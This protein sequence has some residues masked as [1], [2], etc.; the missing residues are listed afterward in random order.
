MSSK[1]EE[2]VNLILSDT[3]LTGGSAV[4]RDEPIIKT[5]SQMSN[6]LPPFLREMRRLASGVDPYQYT[7]TRIFIKQARFAAD[8]EDDYTT[9]VDFFR[10][11]PTY[12]SMND[13]QLRCYFAWRTKVRKGIV[14]HAATS[15]AFVYV[16]EL[17][18]LVGVKSAQ[19]GYDRLCSL[20]K[21]FGEYD[22]SVSYYINLWLTDFV[23]YYGLDP[24]LI[25]EHRADFDSNLL[26]LVHYIEHSDGE[27]FSAILA[28]SS[29]NI[30][31]SKF[32][33]DNKDDFRRVAISVYR[34][35]AQHFDKNRKTSLCENY[36][37][38]VQDYPHR[39]FSSA[40]FLDERKYEHYEYKINEF[41]SY[42]CDR[43]YWRKRVFSGKREKN[44]QLGAMMKAVDCIMRNKFGDPHELQLPKVTKMI[45]KTIEASTDELLEEKQKKAQPKIEIDL[46]VLQSIRSDSA[47]TRDRLIVDEEDFLPEEVAENEP[48]FAEKSDEK[49]DEKPSEILQKNISEN[50]EKFGLN[51]AEFSVLN[52]L[53]YGGDYSQCARSN[54]LLLSVVIDSI[55][56][57]LFDLLGDTAIAFDSDEPHIL[58]DYIDELKGIFAP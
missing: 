43:G 49:I 24:S 15:Y 14:E 12:S 47:Q 37:G 18:N 34:K 55:N 7:D 44:R 4:Y 32:Y 39:M 56:E 9:K 48:I 21:S 28:L 22:P 53:L 50:T 54:G 13:K 41:F 29:Y 35:M 26:T 33:K 25:P 36:F 52:C 17:L 58:D 38:F 5:A 6:Y 20:C 40:L 27:L 23:V 1:I 30:E 42:T 2:L 11:Y 19:E 3:K 46:S 31:K 8:Y 45:V 57:K 10:Y 16:Y 51:Q